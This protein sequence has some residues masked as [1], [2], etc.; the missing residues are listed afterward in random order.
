M[1]L[2]IC[3]IACIFKGLIMSGIRKDL[4]YWQEPKTSARVSTSLWQHL[5]RLVFWDL[6]DNAHTAATFAS[7]FKPFHY[8]PLCREIHLLDTIWK[9]LLLCLFVDVNTS[10]NSWFL[11]MLCIFLVLRNLLVSLVKHFSGWTLGCYK[12]I[13]LSPCTWHVP[14]VLWFW[15]LFRHWRAFICCRTAS[16]LVLKSLR[17]LNFLWV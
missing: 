1:Q 17:P 12:D 8:R 15:A 4:L 13:R 9:G 14:P 2:F 11:R 10:S 5:Q 16:H 7:I 3:L 6:A